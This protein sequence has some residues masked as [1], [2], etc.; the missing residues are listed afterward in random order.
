MQVYGGIRHP[1]TGAV[2][3]PVVQHDVVTRPAALGRAHGGAGGVVQAMCGGASS[4]KREI[5]PA[6]PYGSMASSPRPLRGGSN[7][8][9]FQPLRLRIGPMAWLR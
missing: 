1:R 4:S 8:R 7:E 6:R 2:S 5:W 9:T 3:Q